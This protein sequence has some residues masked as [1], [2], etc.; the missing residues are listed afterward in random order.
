MIYLPTLM[1]LTFS[2]APTAYQPTYFSLSRRI[3]L[4]AFCRIRSRRSG[5]ITR[6]GYRIYP[7]CFLPSNPPSQ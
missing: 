1:W 5:L 6:F 7:F 2:H 4:P 3:L